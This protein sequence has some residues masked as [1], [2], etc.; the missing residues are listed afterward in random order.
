VRWGAAIVVLVVL[1][2]MAPAW[3]QV[4]A[5]VPLGDPVYD[6]L[7]RLADLGLAPGYLRGTRPVTL[8]YA[9]R[10]VH[11]AAEAARRRGEPEPAAVTAARDLVERLRA[12]RWGGVD[13]GGQASLAGGYRRELVESVP[14]SRDARVGFLTPRNGASLAAGDGAAVGLVA[15][16]A[17]GGFAAADLALG[18]DFPDGRAALRLRRGSV[19]A[20]WAGL[21]LQA[22]RDDLA[23]GQARHAPM[24]LSGFAPAFDLVQ[25]RTARPV[26]LPWVFR[27][28]GQWQAALFAARLDQDLP[29]R[30][31][32]L[33]GMRLGLKPVS[34]LELGFSHLYAFGGEGAP[35]FAASRVVEEF[36]GYRRGILS[37]NYANHGFAFDGHLRVSRWFE[38]YAEWYLED[39][40]GSVGGQDSSF[41][42]GLRRARVFGARDD[43]AVEVVRT[44]RIAFLS[45]SVT[46]WNQGHVVTGHPLGPAGT[47]AYAVYTLLGDRGQVLKLRLAVERRGPS[48]D[49]PPLEPQWRVGGL[50]DLRWP[51]LPGRA[52]RVDGRCSLGLQRVLS[53]GRV[54]ANDHFAG[55]AEVVVEAS[56]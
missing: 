41:T 11:E 51:L 1:G 27:Y 13:A 23:C 52:G 7:D 55:L 36:F 35:A 21:E 14:Y 24:I 54:P 34:W 17:C 53:V 39:C 2:T 22:G 50:L 43:L 38:A 10:V 44:T 31:P 29:Y 6:Y 18:L 8:D 12:H 37:S 46:E 42:V 30:R 26:R 20:G 5:N 4:S 48:Y 25:L 47:G 16:G 19:K 9:A 32:W 33:V 15:R 45:S 28:L 49:L 40:C 56:F 3:A